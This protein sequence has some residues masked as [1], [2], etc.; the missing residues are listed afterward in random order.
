MNLSEPF[1]EEINLSDLPRYFPSFCLALSVLG[2]RSSIVSCLADVIYRRISVIRSS[3]RMQTVPWD[4][5]GHQDAAA[6]D[7]PYS[8][9]SSGA[10]PGRSLLFALKI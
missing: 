3:L 4:E 5:V 1:D 7:Y 10:I 6:R 8:G 9:V 2:A